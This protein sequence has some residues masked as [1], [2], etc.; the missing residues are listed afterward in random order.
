MAGRF[1]QGLLR[2]LM[3]DFPIDEV[4]V[5]SACR[6]LEELQHD[7]GRSLVTRTVATTPSGGITSPAVLLDEVVR[8]DGLGEVR[9]GFDDG[10]PHP[11]GTIDT[12]LLVISLVTTGLAIARVLDG[13]GGGNDDAHVLSLLGRLTMFQAL[14]S[15]MMGCFPKSGW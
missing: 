2:L 8:Y 1:D 10:I 7:L 14:R 5:T 4:E 12:I 15:T 13:V 11:H 3:L 6:H 9:V